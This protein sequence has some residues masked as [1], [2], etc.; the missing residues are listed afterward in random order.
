MGRILI[1]VKG[2]KWRLHA[3][4]MERASDSEADWESF[5]ATLTF[6]IP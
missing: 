6:E 5:W 1:P 4:Q 2:G 3:I